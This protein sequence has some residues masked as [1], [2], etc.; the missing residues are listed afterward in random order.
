MQKE[1]LTKTNQIW[2][3]KATLDSKESKQLVMKYKNRLKDSSRY[4]KVYTGNDIPA[5]QRAKNANFRTLLNALGESNLQ[6][7]IANQHT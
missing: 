5:T 7:R 2:G 4:D 3:K 1:W 6:Q